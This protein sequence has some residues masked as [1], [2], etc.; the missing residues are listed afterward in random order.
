MTKTTDTNWM[1]SSELAEDPSAKHPP[2]QRK[3]LSA[4]KREQCCLLI[5]YGELEG[6]PVHCRKRTAPKA[7]SYIHAICFLL[8]KMLIVLTVW[9]LVHCITG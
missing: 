2:F 6:K 3:F 4:R 9:E 5:Q 7:M 8:A 1:E